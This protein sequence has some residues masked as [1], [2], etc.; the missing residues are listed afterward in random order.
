MKIPVKAISSTY[1]PL[2][3]FQTQPWEMISV[4]EWQEILSDDKMK[5]MIDWDRELSI[6]REEPEYV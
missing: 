5:V 3:Y 2:W 4:W 6:R 1:K